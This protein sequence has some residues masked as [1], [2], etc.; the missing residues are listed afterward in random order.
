MPRKALEI[1]RNEVVPKNV[2]IKSDFVGVQ[3]PNYPINT[4]FLWTSGPHEAVMLVALKPTARLHGDDLKETL[5]GRF[6]KELPGVEVSFEAGDIITQV[7]SFGSPTPIEVA[8]QGPN[9]VEH[10]KF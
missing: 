1:I 6:S 5:R 7:M 3:P 10:R 8:V 4:I 9:L 2:E